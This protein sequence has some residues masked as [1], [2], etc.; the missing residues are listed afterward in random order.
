MS[1]K[2]LILQNVPDREARREII[3]KAVREYLNKP[4][5]SVELDR[6]DNPVATGVE[7]PVYLSAAPAGDKLLLAVKDTPVGLDGECLTDYEG[8]RADYGLMAERFFSGEEAEYV[9]EGDTSLDEKERFFKIWTRKKAYIKYMGK[10]MSEFPGFSVV[11]NDRVL[12]RI[13]NVSI[14]K[15]TIAFEGSENYLFAIAG[16]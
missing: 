6:R 10:P 2:C 3:E 5:V 9:R 14:R 16:V 1:L 7:P 4:D 12:S 11:E 13:G 15:F 8:K